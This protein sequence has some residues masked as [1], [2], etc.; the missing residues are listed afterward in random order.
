MPK[1]RWHAAWDRL[2]IVTKVPL[3][4]AVLLTLVLGSMT[5]AAYAVVR[6]SAVSAA[7]AQLERVAR[8]MAGVL[9]EEIESDGPMLR[10]LVTEPAIRDY[11]RRGDRA[12][13]EAVQ[14]L[15]REYVAAREDRLFSVELW[16]RSGER[17]LSVGEEQPPLPAE[18][19]RI[20]VRETEPATGARTG[21]VR[22]AGETLAYPVARAVIEGE[23]LYGFVVERRRFTTAPD[24]LRERSALLGASAHLLLGR[25]DGT[26]WTDLRTKTDGP[27]VAVRL[28]APQRY[29]RHGE[30]VLARSV[31]VG[32]APWVLTLEMPWPDV[33]GAATRFLYAALALSTVLVAAGAAVGSTLSRQNTLPIKRVTEAAELMAQGR[34]VPRVMLDREDEIGR[35]ASSFNRMADQVEHGREHLE[36][37][38]ER[39]RL[40]FEENPVPMWLFDLETL[41]IL[42]VNESAIQRYGWTREEVLRMNLRDMRPPEDVPDFLASLTSTGDGWERP[43][44]KRHWRKDG[45][46]LEV[47]VTRHYFW[48]DGRRV[49]LTAALDVTARRAAERAVEESEQ[50]LRRANA[51][52]EARVQER[53][54]A[55][56]ATNQE[57]E[58]FSY[59]VSH[60]LRAPLRAIVGFSNILQEDHGAELSPEARQHL[61]TIARNA[62]QMGQLID[63]LL[64]FSRMGRHVMTTGTVDMAAVAAEVAEEARRQDPQRYVEIVVGALPP[65]WGERSLL[66]QVFANFIE[67][68]MKFT[69]DRS[70]ARIEV[71]AVPRDGEVVYFVR[72]NGVGFDM[73]YSDK[74]FGVFQ[75]L[76]RTEDFPGT[77]VGLALVKRI[78]ARHGG[79]VWAESEE[80]KGATFYFSLPREP[81][82]A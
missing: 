45:S 56:Q 75:R 27:P 31:A 73:R 51:A 8:Q 7:T 34:P 16:S 10:V 43:G 68:S 17:L 82:R 71:G 2:S 46:L 52:L 74:L 20:L 24:E 13:G 65:V 55:L 69:R 38:V 15:L 61:E 70:P 76:H 40:L 80:G 72:D 11:L 23:S 78:V 47:E 29:E 42:D 53:T 57:L 54:A 58:A 1:P 19:A 48:L 64:R 67:N 22:L 36:Q 18:Q 30:E 39:Y 59:S 50:A 63:D 44:T 33:V 14:A 66:R 60:D 35:L 4:F 25:R 26:L 9:A 49:G 3:T 28:D 41:S 21:P 12:E 32:S 77:G 79:R 6:R 81:R 37:L 5:A 62:R